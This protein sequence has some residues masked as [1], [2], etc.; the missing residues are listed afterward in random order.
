MDY[1]LYCFLVFLF[2]FPRLRVRPPRILFNA[3]NVS[4]FPTILPVVLAIGAKAF[5]TGARAVPSA[6]APIAVPVPTTEAAASGERNAEFPNLPNLNNIPVVS[7]FH[8]SS[9]TS[10][11]EVINV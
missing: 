6:R 1:F 3:P 7:F 8:P 10:E 2:F 11:R 9:E 4:T 5:P